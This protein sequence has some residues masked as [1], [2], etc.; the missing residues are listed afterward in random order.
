VNNLAGERERRELRDDDEMIGVGGGS[1]WIL[2]STENCLRKART[3]RRQCPSLETRA[4]EAIP[5]T[6]LDPRSRSKKM[7]ESRSYRLESVREVDIMQV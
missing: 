1:E 3:L 2:A 5:L 6:Q 4:A 7:W